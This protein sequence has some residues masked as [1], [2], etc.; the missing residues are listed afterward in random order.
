M[1]E[2]MK[3]I[4]VKC[5]RCGSE[6]IIA[7][8]DEEIDDIKTRGIARVGFVHKDHI[9]LVDL[10]QNMYIR[11]AYITPFTSLSSDVKLYFG[12]YRVLAN[13]IVGINVEFIVLIPEKNIM[14]L[15]VCPSCVTNLFD[16]LDKISKF[17]GFFKGSPTGIP[18]T[19]GILGKRCDVLPCNG[20]IILS[21]S[22]P[23]ETKY[24][25]QWLKAICNELLNNGV[26][27]DALLNSVMDYIQS[28]LHRPP[29]AGEL[30]NIVDTD[31]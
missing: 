27:P 15:R 17:T 16:I 8:S 14:D 24:K 31:A 19:I 10:D 13:V 4:T 11:G 20:I 28:N 23:E 12:K 1:G 25:T 22:K 30:A 18:R 6:D 29:E 3:E 26:P 2:G 9:L 21:P 7:L 5:P